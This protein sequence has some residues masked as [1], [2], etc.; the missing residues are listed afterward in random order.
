MKYKI[1]DLFC[2]AGGLSLGFERA[3]FSVLKAVDIEIFL[4]QDL[5]LLLQILLVVTKLILLV[6]DIASKDVEL[7]LHLAKSVLEL[8]SNSR[9]SG[10]FFGIAVGLVIGRQS[11]QSKQ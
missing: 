4:V 6:T 2:G 9:V 1:L 7:E 5:F 3:G 11:H 10:S 8:S